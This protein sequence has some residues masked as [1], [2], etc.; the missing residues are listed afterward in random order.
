MDVLD[1]L[2]N[3][4]HTDSVK[5]LTESKSLS[6]GDLTPLSHYNRKLYEVIQL[7]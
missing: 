2:V 3:S 6:C 7:I 5:K 1:G 4:F